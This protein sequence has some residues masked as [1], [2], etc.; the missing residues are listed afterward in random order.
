MNK[1]FSLAAAAAMLLV[2]AAMLPV[3]LGKEKTDPQDLIHAVDLG[4]SVK[5]A[6]ANLGASSPEDYGGYYQWAGTREVS[7]TSIDLDWDNCPYHTGSS[8]E[9]GW[10]KYNTQSSYGFVDNKTTLE[11]S[12]DAA[13]VNLGGKWRMPTDAEWKELIDN[14][15]W[16]WTSLNGENGYKVRSKKAG[17]TDRRIFLPTAGFRSYDELYRVGSLGCYW[18]SS[19]DTDYPFGPSYVEFDS[20]DVGRYAS[21]RFFGLSVRPVSE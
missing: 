6:N 3:S 14:C 1:V 21:P 12:D 9:S 17:Y 8:Y 10:T 20:V 18:S 19:L 11:A 5:W 4:L 2:S 16:T 7:D 15:T 13:T